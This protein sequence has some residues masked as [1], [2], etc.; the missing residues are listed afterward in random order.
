MIGVAVG[1]DDLRQR[2]ALERLLHGFEMPRLSGAGVDERCHTTADQPR[3]IAVAGIGT[4]IEGV[5][6]NRFQQPD[7]VNRFTM[8]S[9][10]LTLLEEI[11]TTPRSR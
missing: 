4:R 5:N 11:R 10:T 9:I 3:P 1:H 2:C 7:C 6:R 8:L